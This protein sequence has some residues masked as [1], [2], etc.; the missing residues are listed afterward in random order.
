[1][2]EFV[3]L[4][5]KRDAIQGLQDTASHHWI[6]CCKFLHHEGTVASIV[7]LWGYLGDGTYIFDD[8]DVVDCSCHRYKAD[9]AGSALLIHKSI[10]TTDF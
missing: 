9:H 8:G 6:L 3:N 5:G 2:A 7:C 4:P 1:M 10:L